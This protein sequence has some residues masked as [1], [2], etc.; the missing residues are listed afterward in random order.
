MCIRDSGGIAGS[1]M[2]VGE[3]LVFFQCT[4]TT[5]GAW[6]MRSSGKLFAEPAA[7]VAGEK[8]P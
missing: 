3:K 6:L 2:P 4:S 7:V 5:G 1:P 8:L